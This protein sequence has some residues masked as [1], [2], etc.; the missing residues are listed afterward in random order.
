MALSQ[1]A[2]QGILASSTSVVYLECLTIAHSD[3]PAV[4]RLVNNTANIVRTAG[5]YLAFPFSIVTPSQSPDQAPALEIQIDMVDQQVLQA[6]RSIAGKREHAAITYEV[7]NA[8]TPNTIEWGPITFG[9]E[10]VATEG[11]T[12]LK[13]RATFSMGLLNDSFPRALFAPSNRSGL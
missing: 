3:F 10:S 7:I 8:A 1:A 4:L 13:I 6:I 5:T 2:L 12:S 11:L 9:M